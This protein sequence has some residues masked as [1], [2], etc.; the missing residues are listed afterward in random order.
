MGKILS[1]SVAAYNAE[2]WLAKC[3]DSFCIPEIMDKIEVL[4]VN[5]GSADKT[6][7]IAYEYVSKYPNTFILINK[8]NGGHG[9]T[10]NTGIKAA[11]G[12]YFKLVDADDWVTEEGI[13]DLVKIA[14]G[15]SA[16]AIISPYYKFYMNC[17][18]MQI[19]N[20]LQ[21]E[22]NDYG[23][24]IEIENIAEKCEFSLPSL[25]FKTSLLKDNFTEITEKCFFVDI[26]YD[27][28]YSCYIS[29]ALVSII[30][31]YVYRLGNENQSVA[32]K[33]MVKRR[34]QHLTV[35]KKLMEFY[36]NTY[37][38]VTEANS[39]IIKKMISNLYSNQ[40]RILLEI[41]DKTQSKKEL[42]SFI[43]FIKTNYASVYKEIIG[44]GKK[45]KKET[46]ILSVILDKIHFHFY[47]LIY[48]IVHSVK[49]EVS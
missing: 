49:K 5:D 16:D 25:T 15:C 31:V 8:E 45:E 42:S 3:L 24:V 6:A 19:Q 39:Q 38:T 11:T 12:K 40:V 34:D 20:I 28:F 48:K 18:N 27:A 21:C 41:E 9:S 46:I 44:Y 7:E 14:I 35:C 1:I 17:N 37:E 29:N 32:L 23:K 33:N 4:I 13:V 22:F 26:E 30:P 2:K 36:D 10:I 47:G 43:I